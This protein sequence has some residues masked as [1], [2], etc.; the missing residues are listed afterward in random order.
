MNRFLFNARAVA[1]LALAVIL[2]TVAAN[3]EVVIMKDGHVLHGIK[4][5][6]EKAPIIDDQAGQVF[7][8]DKPN[9]MYAIDDG[10]RWVVFPNSPSQV[11][12]VSIEN[13]FEKFSGYS[14]K[15]ERH[16]GTEKFPKSIAGVPTIE[17]DWD[18]KE[19][20]REIKFNDVNPG[21]KHTIKQQITIITP[22]YLRVGSSTHKLARYILTKEFPPAQIRTFLS[23]HPDLAEEK[24]KVEPDKREK[25]IRFW[26]QADW[27]D[28]A[29]KDLS[30]LLADAPGEKERYARLKAEVDGLR[31]E[32]LIIEI[33]RA[34]DAGRHQWAIKAL[35]AFPKE[36]AS[37]PVNQKVIE[38]RAEYDRRTAR[39]DAARRYLGE[40]AKKVGAQQ[41]M[42]DGATTVRNEVHLDTLSRLDQ[43]TT[44][45]E[46]AEKDAN[47]KERRRPDKSPEEL[48]ASAITGWHLGKVAA[49]AKVET[50][51][52][53]WETRK[54]ALAYLRE[55]NRAEREKI[56]KAYLAST[57][58]LAY[59]DLEKLVSLLPP[60]E[61]PATPPAGLERGK[62][63]PTVEQP[64][65]VEFILRL[66]EEYQPGRSYPLLILLPDPRDDK[67]PDYMLDR[68]ADLPTRLGYIV[69]VP[70]WWDPLK[71][72]YE[73]S[74]EEHAAVLKLMRHLRRTYQVDSDRVFLWGN[75]EGAS[76]A[77][78]MGGSHPDLFAGVVPV[79]PSVCQPLYIPCQYWVNFQQLPVYLVMGDRFGP[80]VE[81]IRMM[82]ERW[83]PKGFPSL[84]V[85]YKGRGQ[86]W[87]AQELPYAFDWMG[88]KRRSDPG[89]VLGPLTMEGRTTHPGFSSVRASDNRFHWLSS[90]EV[91]PNAT[92]DPVLATRDRYPAPAKFSARIGEGNAI[93]VKTL[94][95][96]QVTVWFGKGMAD[97]TKPVKVTVNGG[98]PTMKQITPQIPV[99]M[100]DLY[101]RG[102]R[103]RPYFEMMEF[104]VR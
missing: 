101:E 59:D 88:R 66:P 38:L 6:K 31:A 49:E 34:R 85:S 44:L 27:L 22:H 97:Y 94:G 78:D 69:A 67:V 65:G 30:K 73:Y 84:V 11:A 98:K 47:A 76:M 45:A 95:L 35:A 41:W 24:G 104:Q 26:I 7:L 75:G 79:N 91:N 82:S 10:A 25:L 99:L 60:P 81:A 52:K 72:K 39:F 57:S 92:M 29:D 37:K 9:G 3:A 19:W 5:L 93:T 63:P 17:K 71:N 20:T 46:R 62:L 102:D 21:V 13:R 80:S 64:M 12:D 87:F 14:P 50:A 36:G 58:A 53:C 1:A 68:F 43:F 83:M 18:P 54:M 86:E 70:Q 56:L 74:K 23:N 51:Y 61:A 90:N 89:R 48:V 33:E 40:L 32:R 100:E 42:I 28:E 77:L 4:I 55:N 96:R 15:G 16:A 8:V 103:Q 2:P